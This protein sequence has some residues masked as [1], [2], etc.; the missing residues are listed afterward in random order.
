MFC[1]LVVVFGL[2]ACPYYYH[3]IRVNLCNLWILLKD[4]IP[5]RSL[6]CRSLFGR[7][8]GVACWGETSGLCGKRILPPL[9]LDPGSHGSRRLTRI[10]GADERGLVLIKGLL[11]GLVLVFGLQKTGSRVA[12]RDDTVYSLGVV[13]FVACRSFLKD[14]ITARRPG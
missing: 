11:L 14:W 10:K 12:A 8:N 7:G 6:G 5:G 1:C 13:C 9:K 3:L 2:D 4:W